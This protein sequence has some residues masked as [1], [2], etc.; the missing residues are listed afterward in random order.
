MIDPQALEVQYGALPGFVGRLL[1]RTADA[2]PAQIDQLRTVVNQGDCQAL[3]YHAHAVNGMAANL[4]LKELRV[5]A[6]AT[7]HV[8]RGG[9]VAQAIAL[10]ER[11]TQ[12]VEF[13]HMELN[14]HLGTPPPSP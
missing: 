9:D 1:R 7:E 8:A 14:Q 13:L 12:A 3:A 2:L 10:A 4:L 6:D 5:L 11:L